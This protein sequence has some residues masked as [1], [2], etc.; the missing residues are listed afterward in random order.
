MKRD[1]RLYPARHG[2]IYGFEKRIFCGFV[3]TSLTPT[4][5]LQMERL[6]ERLR[7]AEIGVIYASDLQRSFRGA[8]IIAKDHDVQVFQFAELRELNFGRWEGLGF[9]DLEEQFP[10]ELE[11]RMTNPLSF[12][13]PEGETILNLSKRIVKCL[14][15]IIN[16]NRGKDI[17]ILGHKGVNRV[18]LCHILD[19]DLSNVFSFEQDYG[20]LNIIDFFPD[21]TKVVKLING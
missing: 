6:A 19:M 9:T 4:G 18:I 1:S 10:G 5:I 11:K 8:Q 20:C 3:D 7:P 12:Q 15:S 17:L 16:G 13:I 14:N 2:Q 21:N